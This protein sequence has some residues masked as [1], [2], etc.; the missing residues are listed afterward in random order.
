MIPSE[1]LKGIEAFVTTADA[2]SFTAAGVRLNL[3]NSAVSKSVAR[4]E[5][6]LGSRLF[7]RTTRRLTLTDVGA[8]FY[9]TCVRVLGDLADAEAVLAAHRSEIVG[10]LKIDVPVAF[11]RMQAMPLLL[12]FAERHP[13]LRPS[14]TFTDR[15]V[16][17]VEEGIDV[18]IRIGASDLRVDTLG[19]RHLGT[20]RVI[21]CAAPAYL[22]RRGTPRSADDLSAFDCI[23]YGRADGSTIPWRFAGDAGLVEERTMEPRIVLG[24]AEAQVGAVK[25]GFGIAQLATWLIED[26]LA[27][28]ELVE[29]LPDRA[30]AGLALHLVWPRR[31]QLSPKVNAVLD[32]L[33]TGLRIA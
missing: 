5:A 25:A 9:E 23:L 15:K 28:G 10:R 26:E 7:E 3:T 24:S 4:L 6:R 29:I 32:A 14:I 17:I 22:D 16:D 11:G 30:T 31:R 20:E 8:A 1:R 19:H 27:R 18:A 13:N 33:T 2:G 12:A 21:F